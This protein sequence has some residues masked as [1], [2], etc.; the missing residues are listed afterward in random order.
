MKRTNPLDF[1]AHAQKNP[2]LSNRVL[3]AVERGNMVTAEEILQIAK[4]FGYAFTRQKFEQAVKT[5]IAKQFKGKD[6]SA[7]Q[8]A[9]KK[10]KPIVKKPPLSSCA[11]GCLS[12]TVSWHPSRSTT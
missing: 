12:Y 2:K 1:L 8:V 5:T 4:E 9:K 7:E 6:L 11:R 3:A 10:K